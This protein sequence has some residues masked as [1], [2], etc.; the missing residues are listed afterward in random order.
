M[1]IA[2]YHSELDRNLVNHFQ[3]PVVRCTLQSK[4]F[5]RM[6]PGI[7]HELK[8][9]MNPSLDYPTKYS[10][11]MFDGKQGGNTSYGQKPAFNGV[12]TR[13]F[14][15]AYHMADVNGRLHPKP[16]QQE[17]LGQ[18]LKEKSPRAQGP[19][20]TSRAVPP[21]NQTESDTQEMSMV[22][23][24]AFGI[25]NE[26]HGSPF[27]RVL[28]K[29]LA[30]KPKVEEPP[31]RPDSVRSEDFIARWN[32]G[33][34]VPKKKEVPISHKE[35]IDV[36]KKYPPHMQHH[37]HYGWGDAH[38]STSL[39]K[40]RNTEAQRAKDGI[41]DQDHAIHYINNVR[42]THTSISRCPT[43]NVIPKRALPQ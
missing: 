21:R 23:N 28:K 31:S 19:E 43:T 17:R 26:T 4:N 2:C 40:P 24:T 13:V 36:S 29:G 5:Q 10:R 42:T 3:K 1:S 32:T 33:T 11:G 22:S 6:L 34:R 35:F 14:K 12:R 25:R 7:D 8:M 37:H 9:E 39:Y 38:I 30:G 15:D 16:L 27:M 41:Q 18:A 20:G